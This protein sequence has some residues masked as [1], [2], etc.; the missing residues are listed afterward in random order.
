MCKE[1]KRG[2]WTGVLSDMCGM[3]VVGEEHNMSM[4]EFPKRSGPLRW[5]SKL[6][7]IPDGEDYDAWSDSSLQDIEQLVRRTCK[8][9]G[10]GVPGCHEE[11]LAARERLL[12]EWLGNC[13]ADPHE[14]GS[15]KS[16]GKRLHGG[17]SLISTFRQKRQGRGRS[18]L[19]NELVLVCDFEKHNIGCF[20]C[21]GTY[22]SYIKACNVVKVY[23]VG[24]TWRWH[25]R[26]SVLHS[27][28]LT[29]E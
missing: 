4:A 10:D 17:F 12:Q 28:P 7:R 22:L 14:W 9:A 3:V 15:A 1:R 27:I 20:L 2:N 24:Y 29:S 23:R 16:I 6:L 5:A 25:D 26:R 19:I 8:S 18:L 13:P 11:F 21:T